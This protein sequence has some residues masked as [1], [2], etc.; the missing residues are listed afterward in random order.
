MTETLSS[1]L[2]QIFPWP[3]PVIDPP[4]AYARLRAENP[5]VRVTLTGGK[6]AWLVTRYDDVRA[7]LADPRVSAD[8][9]DP[10]FPNF[11]FVPAEHERSFLRMDPPEHTLFRRLLSK[12]FMVRRVESLR[13]DIQRLVDETIDAMLAQP[14]RPVDLV[15]HLALPVPSTVLSWILGVRAADRAFFNKAAEELLNATDVTDPDALPRALRANASLR[16]YIG[17]LA[18]EKQA[19]ED[20][21]DDIL[22]Q[23]VLAARDGVIT[24]QDIINSGLVLIVAGHDTTASMTALGTLTLLQHPD[25]LAELRANPALI[26]A[27]IEELLR[28]LTIV[29]L[30][31]LRVATEPIEIGGQVIPAGDGIIPLNLSAN[32][33]DAHYPDA[34]TF[35]IHRGARDHFAFGYGVHQ[36][37]GQQLARVELQVIFET[38]LRRIPTLSLAAPVEEIPFKIWSPINGVLKLPVTW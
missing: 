29:H 4:A 34:A 3:R 14:D 24:H 38:L 10:G 16:A 18:A 30:I 12:N 2:A 6:R 19:Q 5:V 9:R 11:G 27:A 37:I 26:P 28:Y 36:C 17:E 21:G 20:P 31:V 13:P 1:T 8:S 23:L 33:D 35:D 25:Q 15:E 22:G 7:I 32:R